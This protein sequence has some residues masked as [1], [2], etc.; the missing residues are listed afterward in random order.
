MTL[1]TR[2]TAL[3]IAVTL[4]TNTPGFAQT[5]TTSVSYATP[6][7]GGMVIQSAGGPTN[8][9]IVGYAVAQ[10]SASTTPAGAAIFDLRQNGVLVAEAGVPGMAAIASGRVYAEVNGS[11]NTG[12]AF[13]NSSDSP[14]TI[15][16]NFTDQN[17]NDFGQSSFVL[18]ANMQ[19]ARF[20]SESP[21]RATSFAGTFTFNASAPVGVVSLRTAVNERGNFLIFT[22]TVTPLPG[23]FSS[24]TI[25]MGHFANG[26]G[27][28][29]EVVLVNTSDAAIS[30]TV[31]FL[32]EGTATLPGTPIILNV[33]GQTAS[34][35][36]YSI[37]PRSSVKLDTMGNA[38]SATQVGSILITPDSASVAPSASVVFSLSE[39][40]VTVARA[41]VQTQ[42]PGVAFRSFVEVNSSA[43]IPGAIQSAIAISNNSTASA[44]VNFELTGL[45]GFNTGLTASVVVPPSGHVSKFVNELFPGLSMPFQGVL[46][47]LSGS[48]IVVV[49]L[50]IRYNERG[51]LLM[52]TTP[53]A[54]EASPAATGPLIFPQIVDQGGYSTEFVLFSGSFGQSTTGMLN[55][56]GQNGQPLNITEH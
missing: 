18:G 11:V 12:V 1:A 55:F 49:S 2:I 21:F 15:S 10:P 5:T 16:F 38:G 39:N 32:N 8:P 14:V 7:R 48:S 6:D 44:T 25:L 37:R 17:G 24:S 19:I 33:N 51:D 41:S 28:T 29:T 43:A 23:T 34:T 4:M 31:Q 27:W 22:Q 3:F 13:A 30:G 54:N 26:G 56:F 36:T 45:N 46:R 42:A 53:V 50:R 35:F 52:T 40:G 20:L 47:L 9:P